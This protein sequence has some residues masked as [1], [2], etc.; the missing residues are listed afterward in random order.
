MCHKSLEHF[1]HFATSGSV[2]NLDP[3]T[4]QAFSNLGVDLT[5]LDLDSVPIISDV[6]QDDNVLLRSLRPTRKKKKVRQVKCVKEESDWDNDDLYEEET[7]QRRKYVS[8]SAV[9]LFLAIMPL[10]PKLGGGCNFN[11]VLLTQSNGS[12]VGVSHFREL[13]RMA[14]KKL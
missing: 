10:L 9:T 2:P 8:R 6:K 11:V 1:Y 3:A 4:V 5:S 13:L 7:S 14:K 12:K